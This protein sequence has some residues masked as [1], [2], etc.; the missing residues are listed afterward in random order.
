MKICK[1]EKQVTAPIA[2]ITRPM[3]E[4][5]LENMGYE[6]VY[7]LTDLARIFKVTKRTL[8]TWRMEG[9]LPLFDMGGRFYISHGRLM[10]LIAEKEGGVR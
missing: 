9:I 3:D 8:Y 6:I 5:V 4:Q 10:Q 7:D 2:A 1:G